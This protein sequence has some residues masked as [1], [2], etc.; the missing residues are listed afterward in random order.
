MRYFIII[1]III[2]IIIELF[3]LKFF[4]NIL[5]LCV[6]VHC[7]FVFWTVHFLNDKEK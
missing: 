1:I 2:I 3:C 6:H 5:F 4:F 7:F